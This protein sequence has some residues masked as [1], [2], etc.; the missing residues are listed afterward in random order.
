MSPLEQQLWKNAKPETKDA[1][2]CPECKLA[3]GLDGP[4]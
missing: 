1:A 3:K 2:H 4:L